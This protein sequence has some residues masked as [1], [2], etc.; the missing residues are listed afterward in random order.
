ML[1]TAAAANDTELS[2]KDLV[3]YAYVVINA[4]EQEKASIAAFNDSLVS[5]RDIILGATFKDPRGIKEGEF[6]RFFKG[7]DLPL[8]LP[9]VEFLT[10]Q[11]VDQ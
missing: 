9:S 5:D 11:K 3:D 10:Q 6:G 2:A 8:V 1:E 7:N 4:L